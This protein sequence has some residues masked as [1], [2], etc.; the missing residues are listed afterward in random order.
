MSQDHD[1]RT[2]TRYK[3]IRDYALI[4][5]C[6]GAA[7][8][9][10]DGSVDWCC[11]KR[12]DADPV[13]CRLLDA[14]KGGFFSIRPAEEYDSER[15]YTPRT[16]ML[17]TTFRTARG[18]LVVRDFMPV[19]RRPDAGTHDYV[20]LNAPHWLVRIAECTEGTVPVH[21]RFRPSVDFA[22]RRSEI[23]ASPDGLGVD[24]GPYLYTETPF[25]LDGDKAKADVELKSGN[26]LS[27][28]VSAEA[29]DHPPTPDLMARLH[30]ITQAFW[31]EWADYCRYRGP[32]REE[33]VRSALVLKLLTYAPTGGL[34]AAPTTSLPEEIGGERN[35]DYR[36]CWLRDATFTLYALSALGYSGEARGFADYMESRCGMEPHHLQIM[37]GVECETTLTEHNLD[38]LEGYA[39]SRPVRV[40]NDAYTQRQL[41]VYGELLDWALLYQTL[42]GR[43]DRQG[44]VFLRALADHVAEHWEEPG[45]GLWEMRTEPR[46]YVYSRMMCWAALDRAIRLFGRRS[47]WEHAKEKIRAS[48]TEHG[49]NPESGAL[50]QTLE[51]AGMDAA[52]LLAP[53]VGFPLSDDTL[54]ATLRAIEKELRRGDYLLRYTSDD[55]LSGNEGA[56]LICS[57][58]LVQAKLHAGQFDE[59]RSLFDQLL[60][61][62]NDVGL[63]SEEIDPHNHAFLGN[64][65]QAFTHLALILCASNI[66]LYETKGREALQGTH[67]DRARYTVEATEG[68]RAIWSAFKQTHRVRRLVSSRSSKLDEALYR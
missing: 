14:D 41:D 68:W 37:Y 2:D 62:D 34:V 33:V 52:L 23:K 67:A 20:S 43:F 4:G 48:I 57:F 40:G 58:W 25:S 7:L 12:F 66:E 28:S 45:N 8:V 26:R 36:Y 39:G 51:H 13:F 54:Q 24:D 22:W 44:Q 42:G 5:D 9:S 35:W 19:G 59:A 50:R 31:E 10:R 15:A 55:G 17:T 56:F 30:G 49:I 65:P 64:F 53:Q 6:H 11:L 1:S 3:P 38:H 61:C 47:D 21:I 32:Y 29:L 16:N 46:H 60:S 63:Y 18:Q 27:F